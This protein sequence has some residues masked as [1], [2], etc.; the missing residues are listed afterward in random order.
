MSL[1][2]PTPDAFS[3]VHA[4]IKLATDPAACRTRLAKL[5]KLLEQ[6]AAAEQRLAERSAAFDAKVAAEKAE[7]D[8]RKAALNARALQLSH[9]E[10]AAEQIIARDRSDR[11]NRSRPMADGMTITREPA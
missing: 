1:E 3:M 4:L 8:E 6:T 9:R 10:A 5:Q 11:L 2:T 7:L